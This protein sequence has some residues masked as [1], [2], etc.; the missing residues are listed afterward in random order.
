MRTRV[1]ALIAA[2]GL[3]GVPAACGG[4]DDDAA[5]DAP[6]QPTATVSSAGLVGTWKERHFPFAVRFTSDGK[7]V[8]DGDG[9]V[10][11]GDE[12]QRGTYTVDG[13]KIKF[14][15]DEEGPIACAGQEWEWQVRRSESG[16]LS[17]VLLQEVCQTKAGESFTLR[18]L[19]DS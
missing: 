2:T 5:S 12:Y 15:A 14:V 1:V 18:K 16:R 19:T 8:M 17:A 7:F 3:L 6:S 4:D 9:S 13:S 11:D 10:D